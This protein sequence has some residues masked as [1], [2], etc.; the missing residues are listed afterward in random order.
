MYARDGN[1][2]SHPRVAYTLHDNMLEGHLVEDG[3]ENLV[4]IIIRAVVAM[5]NPR[6]CVNYQVQFLG[7]HYRYTSV[8]CLSLIIYCRQILIYPLP[9]TY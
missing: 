3:D 8:H 1:T 7:S 9:G 6:R 4:S 5:V 2:S